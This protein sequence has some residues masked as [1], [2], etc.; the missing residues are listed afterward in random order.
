MVNAAFYRGLLKAAQTATLGG[1]LSSFTSGVNSLPS[2]PANQPFNY[3]NTTNLLGSAASKI[4][5]FVPSGVKG[6][7]S[8]V[9]NFL[10]GA[11]T[12]YVSPIAE[13]I[14]KMPVSPVLKN[15]DI[16][17]T[18]RTIPDEAFAAALAVKNKIAPYFNAL[19]GVEGGVNNAETDAV[20]GIGAVQDSKNEI[21]KAIKEKL[22]GLQPQVDSMNN[23]REHFQNYE[24]VPM[25]RRMLGL[26]TMRPVIPNTTDFD[27]V[28]KVLANPDVSAG[29]NYEFT[30]DPQFV[31]SV[32]K[33]VVNPVTL[34]SAVE[35]TGR[36]ASLLGRLRAFGTTAAPVARSVGGGMMTGGKLLRTGGVALNA[37]LEVPRVIGHGGIG[38]YVDDTIH[39]Q[40][41]FGTG[42]WPSVNTLVNNIN[43]PIGSIGGSAKLLADPATYDGVGMALAPAENVKGDYLNTLF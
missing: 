9:G 31:R 1:P 29:V 24:S 13:S 19:H 18:N 36:F 11:R 6:L 4:S 37:A 27:N 3:K 20:P 32:A 40:N 43:S 35:D 2:L 5:P 25:W 16:N 34:G 30:H 17:S 23:V 22:P 12:N 7:N 8:S 38:P 15:F 26:S 28:Q 14:Q 33:G 10:Q 39:R 21:W 42:I 41:A